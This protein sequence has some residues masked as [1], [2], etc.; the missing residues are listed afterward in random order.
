MSWTRREVCSVIPALV[1]AG[2][3][4]PTL[5][6]QDD[7]LPSATFA[8]ESLPV[9]DSGH[10][11]IRPIIKGK[12]ATGEHIETHETTLPPNGSPH[13]AHHHVHSEMW[14]IREGTVELTINGTT[15]RLGPGGL[16]FVHSNE[17]HG[18][19]NVGTGPAKYFVVAI[20]PGADA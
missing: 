8:F 2:P 20:G 5:G 6:T 12:L 15:H 7:S 17:E 18:I 3:T 16:G 9:Q 1:T 10:A 13:P 14:L 11:Q 19:K 4:F